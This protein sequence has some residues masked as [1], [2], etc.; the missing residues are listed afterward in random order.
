MLEKRLLEDDNPLKVIPSFPLASVKEPD[1]PATHSIPFQATAL[2]E[3]VNGE[4]DAV[5]LIPSYEYAIV[6]VPSPPATH[7][8]TLQATA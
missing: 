3:D 4:V 7:T 8:V 6:F 5:Q 1:P 2:H